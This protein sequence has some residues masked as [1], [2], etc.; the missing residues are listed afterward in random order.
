[1]LF[2]WYLLSCIKILKYHTNCEKF[3]KYKKR[4]E[5]TKKNK[6]NKIVVFCRASY[7]RKKR[8]IKK[9]GFFWLVLV[10]CLAINKRKAIKKQTAK[11]RAD[12]KKKIIYKSIK[13]GTYKTIKK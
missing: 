6:K 9:W 4:K 1:M 3:V 5:K 7:R 11:N 13:N 10:V 8:K 12:S 2:V